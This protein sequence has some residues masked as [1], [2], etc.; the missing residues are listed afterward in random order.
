M[1]DNSAIEIHGRE[2]TATRI[3]DAPRALVWRAFTDPDH[4]KHW[5]GPN[6]FTCTFHEF[7]LRPGGAWRFIM[8]GPDGT[9]YKNDNVFVTID[10]MERIVFDHVSFPKHSVTMRFEDAGGKTKLVFKQ[11]FESLDDF[12]KIKLIS[13]PGLTQTLDRLAAHLPQIDPY[14]R[15]LT[16]TRTFAAPR[17]LVW[18]AWT[19]PKQLAKWWGPHG[20]SNP[21]CEINL[22]P[23]GAIHIV[24]RAP[25][26]TDYPM[27][28]EFRE[29]APPERL[30]FTSYPVD[31]EGRP[32]I[33]GLTTV[34]FVERDGATEMTLHTRAIGLA[35]V[36]V[37]MI[38]GMAAGWGQSI[39][40][41]AGLVESA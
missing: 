33:D 21:V 5:W 12:E 23:G 7:D 26:G 1:T 40:R 41:L 38:A 17:A 3:F 14:R 25:D 31:G 9:D 15:E 6:G 34:T 20:F 4:L 32:L 11:L 19:D 24:M 18:R 2:V 39:E 10:W 37:A 30:V 27:R 29:I 16:I 22:N 13:M 28:G 8:H 36:A 35:P